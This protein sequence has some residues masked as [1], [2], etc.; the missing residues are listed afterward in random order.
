MRGLKTWMEESLKFVNL[1]SYAELKCS[2]V[3]FV[4]AVLLLGPQ[5]VQFVSH[6]LGAVVFL[7][8]CLVIYV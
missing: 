1:E 4:E 2:S 7:K 6:L 8:G 3:E 5:Q